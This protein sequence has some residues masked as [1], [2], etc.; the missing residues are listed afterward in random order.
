MTIYG[1]VL[2][3]AISLANW[4]AKTNITEKA[5][6]RLRVVD[7]L[8]FHNNNVSLTARHFGLNRETV[9]IWLRKFRRAG[10][11]GLNDG[12]HRPKNV[13]KP[14]TSWEIVNEI[15]KTRKQYPAWSKYKIKRILS[16][17]NIVVSASTIGRVLK[18]KDLISKKISVKRNRAAKNPRKRFPKGLRIAFAGDMVQVDTKHVNLMGGKRIY[19]FTAIDVLTKKRVLRYY[20]SLASKNGADFLRYYLARFA[21]QTRAIQTDNG[22]EFLKHFDVL[23]KELNIPHYFIYPRTP[24]QNTY[25]EVSHLADKNEFYLQGNI[26]CD[27]KSM[28]KRLEEWEYVWNHVRPHEALNYLTPDEYLDRLQFIPLSTQKVIVLQT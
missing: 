14:T 5:K 7:W 23:C 27:I 11:L 26:G 19:Q 8:R 22:P 2:P 28:Q 25:V 4:A 17:Q 10:M 20:P 13:R 15:I 24:K 3:G 6:Q 18:R 9:G 16:R 21:F 1:S 12:S